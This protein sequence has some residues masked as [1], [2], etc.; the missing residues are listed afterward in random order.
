MLNRDLLA[1]LSEIEAAIKKFRLQLEESQRSESDF[2]ITRDSDLTRRQT[3]TPE[4]RR[5]KIL[6]FVHERTPVAKEQLWR[7]ADELGMGRQGLGGFFRK[8]EVDLPR[9][10]RV[11]S[12]LLLME[13]KGRYQ[14]V[15]LGDYGQEELQRLQSQ[16]PEIF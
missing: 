15:T 11:K 5:L 2:E 10:G 9:I 7:L 12:S 8:T 13:G 16:F 4:V 6:Q 1:M 14:T 3:R